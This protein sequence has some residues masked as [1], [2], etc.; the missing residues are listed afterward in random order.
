MR[1]KSKRSQKGFTLIELII[2]IAILGVLALL[3]VPNV[4]GR[5]DAARRG[6]DDANAKAIENAINQYIA[7]SGDE[8]C[9]GLGITS[10]TAEDEDAKAV[11]DKLRTKFEYPTT[12]NNKKEYGPYLSSNAADTPQQKNGYFVIT[13]KNGEA[14]V[15][16]K[17]PESTPGS[18]NSQ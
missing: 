6:V 10:D 16:V 13:I 11:I 9:E 3:I 14:T 17:V 15:E 8:T 12:G 4:K 5:V 7:E 2:V 1:E 18:L